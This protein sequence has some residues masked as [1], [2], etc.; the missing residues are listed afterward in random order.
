[1]AWR[2]EQTG[3]EQWHLSCI[4]LPEVVSLIH[5]ELRSRP[6]LAIRSLRIHIWTFQTREDVE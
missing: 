6:Q 5:G 3:I 2:P 1:M 4:R